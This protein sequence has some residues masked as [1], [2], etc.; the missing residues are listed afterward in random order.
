MKIFKYCNV[1]HAFYF[2]EI[3]I[4]NQLNCKFI[5]AIKNYFSSN[6]K[7]IYFFALITLIL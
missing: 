3:F 1:K 7:I 2:I 5:L 4:H 6:N